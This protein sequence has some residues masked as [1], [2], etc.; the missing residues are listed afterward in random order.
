MKDIV[1]SFDEARILF[2]SVKGFSLLTLETVAVDVDS[3]LTGR[4]M[5]S[6]YSDECI[7]V[8]QYKTYLAYIIKN[9]KLI[10]GLMSR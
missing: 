8:T 7:S 2:E 3:R 9:S 4:V 6:Y 5:K 10:I 1:M